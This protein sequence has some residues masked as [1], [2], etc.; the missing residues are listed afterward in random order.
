M[1]HGILCTLI[2]CK[3][4]QTCHNVTIWV[5]KTSTEVKHQPRAP[6]VPNHNLILLRRCCYC[7]TKTP[8]LWHMTLQHE[9]KL[10]G[11]SF[12]WTIL[13]FENRPFFLQHLHTYS[14]TG[15]HFSIL[16]WFRWQ[17]W[18]STHCTTRQQIFPFIPPQWCNCK[19]SPA[20]APHLQW[21]VNV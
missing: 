10:V 2:R 12:R 18:K 6:E 15:E 17:F 3:G 11:A 20:L 14:S 4:Y 1:Q 19:T 5:R 7:A 8:T 21:L 9:E 16:F 13:P